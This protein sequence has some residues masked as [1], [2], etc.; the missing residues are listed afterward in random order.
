[1]KNAAIHVEGLCKEFDLLHSGYASLKG[2][3]LWWKN[4]RRERLRALRDVS[5]SV[6]PG[7]C[8]AVVGK[9]GAGKSTLLGVLARVYKP[10][11]GR[12]ELDGRVAPLL[13]LGAGFHPDLTG[14]E[15][16]FFNGV[17]LGLTRR[18]V[19]ERMDSIV[20]FSEIGDYID[21]PVRTY[22]SGMLLRLGFSVAV[23]VDASILL[24]D[25]ALAVGDIE[26]QQKCLKRIEE[27]RAGGGAIL[28]VSHDM[29]AVR[30]AADRAV[31]MRSG[32]VIMDGPTGAVIDAYEA[33]SGTEP[34]G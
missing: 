30:Q 21:A 8:V 5:L 24:V 25:E 7:E 9:N 4:K 11:S 3:L 22:S 20:T 31:W 17:I 33:E 23:H 13:E 15:N 2:M 34:T 12:V 6:R 1:M 28:F 27:F 19:A 29:H 16:V 14:Y 18:E 26:F 10:T 32:Q